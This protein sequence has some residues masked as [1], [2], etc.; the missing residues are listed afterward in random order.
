MLAP[1]ETVSFASLI[2]SVFPEAR[3]EAL[4]NIEHKFYCFGTQISRGFKEHAS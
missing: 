2:P 1:R 3:D 4:G